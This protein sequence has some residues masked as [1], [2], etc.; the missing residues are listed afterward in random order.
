VNS[1]LCDSQAVSRA[2]AQALRTLAHLRLTLS[3]AP[4][5]SAGSHAG[6]GT[7]SSVD[8]QDHRPYFPGDDPRHIDWAAYARS[9]HYSM[10]LFREEVCPR[11]D[12][13]FDISSSMFFLPEKQA[14][15][16]ALFFFCVESAHKERASLRVYLANG[17]E[18][19]ALSEAELAARSFPA[20]GSSKVRPPDLGQV[21]FREGTSRILISDLL[22]AAAPG[23]V[24]QALAGSKSPAALI[25]P[26]VAQECSPQ[27]LG[28]IDFID[29]EGGPVQSQHVDS[30]TLSRYQELYVR[31]FDLWRA[32]AQRFGVKMCRVSA[33]GDLAA[34]LLSEGAR[35]GLVEAWQ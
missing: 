23:Q 15:A 26:Y 1:Q 18:V 27:W 21:P 33:S 30:P 11:V 6:F 16:L 4:R 22:Y 9:G 28:N 17:A 14:C 3:G 25:V 32:E 8:F 7:G 24:M 13:V 29:C 10:K 19:V 20:V 2:Y 35:I 12:L 5:G 34:A 31:H